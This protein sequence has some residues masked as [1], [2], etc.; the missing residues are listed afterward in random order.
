MKQVFLSY[1]RLDLRKA[2]KLYADLNVS[3]KVHVWFDQNDLLP[4]LKWRPAIRKAIRESRYFVALLS[5]KSTSTKGY[6]HSELREA[7]EVMREFPEDKIFLI[8]TRLDSCEPP[9]E[10]LKELTYADLFPSWP[11]GVDRLKKALRIGGQATVKKTKSSKLLATRSKAAPKERSKSGK[12]ANPA[13]Y[14]Y[15]IGLADLDVGIRELS[16]VA[17]GLKYS[18]RLF[19]FTT[20]HITPSRK[21]QISVDHIP[22]LDADGFSTHFYRKIGPLNVD[23][24]VGLTNRLLQ[25]TDEKYTY[26]NYLGAPSPVDERVI[27]T[28][29]RAL[30]TYADQAGISYRVALA[31]VLTSGLASYFLD[32]DYHDAI[33]GCPL[34]FTEDHS[35]MVKG[36]AQGS[37]CSSCSRVLKRKDPSLG[38]AL[39]AMLRWGRD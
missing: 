17:R 39:N 7:I 25:F 2:R 36:L 15:R 22:H 18:Q 27:F 13:E 26:T 21:A 19:Y 5:D 38:L 28:S 6:R 23:N 35:E 16:E 29:I 8:P 9:V 10:E 37:F 30:D 24:V 20:T 32:I 4:G 31:Y 3:P 33:R 11:N 12:R 14:H 1:A 34:D